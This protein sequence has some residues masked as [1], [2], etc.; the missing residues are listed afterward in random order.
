MLNLT[1][2]STYFEF[3]HCPITKLKSRFPDVS[4]I[5][6][7]LLLNVVQQKDSST[8]LR[9]FVHKSVPK[10][11]KIL[12]PVK[13]RFIDFQAPGCKVVSSESTRRRWQTCSPPCRWNQ[14]LTIK[15]LNAPIVVK[16]LVRALLLLDTIAE[17]DIPTVI[18]K[19][20]RSACVLRLQGPLG[21]VGEILRCLQ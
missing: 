1:L 5:S 18:C 8:F 11:F 21:S 3:W 12:R 20:G 19:D 2:E 4:A 15:A 7:A 14:N 6:I 17:N 13:R 10:H 9:S 16:F